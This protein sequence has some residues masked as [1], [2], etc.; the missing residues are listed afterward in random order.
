M[1]ERV[2]T[3]RLCQALLVGVLQQRPDPPQLMLL[4]L[5]RWMRRQRRRRRLRGSWRELLGKMLWLKAVSMATRPLADHVGRL[6]WVCGT[7]FP[8]TMMR[9][10]GRR[11]QTLPWTQLLPH[12]MHGALTRS[13]PP[14]SHRSRRIRP[15]CHH[16]RHRRQLHRSRHHCQH[17]RYIRCNWRCSHCRRGPSDGRKR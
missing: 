4:Y 5:M 13:N 6:Q 2:C 16:R 11:P 10:T 17:C 15:I 8:M 14:R 9:L 3:R 7:A 12:H 1:V